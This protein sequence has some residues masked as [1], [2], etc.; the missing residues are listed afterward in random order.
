[1]PSSEATKLQSTFGL[2]RLLSQRQRAQLSHGTLQ[3]LHPAIERLF[4]HEFWAHWDNDLKLTC[5]Q[6]DEM[7]AFTAKSD[8]WQ[9][10][11]AVISE[12]K[13]SRLRQQ[14]DEQEA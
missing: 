14:E 4:E 12:G 1:M 10:Q 3:V 13:Q 6:G 7:E 11:R 8:R 2:L 9:Q 5:W